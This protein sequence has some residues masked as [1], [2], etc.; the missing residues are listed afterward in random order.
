MQ[1]IDQ[2]SPQ[3]APDQGIWG[4]FG[5]DPRN[6]FTG[7]IRRQLPVFFGL[8]ALSAALGL[9]YLFTAVPTYI[10]TASMLIDTRKAQVFEQQTTRNDVVVDAG[11]VQSQIEVLKSENVSRAVIK[12]LKLTNDPEFAGSKD[13]GFVRS[14]LT[15]IFAI[16]GGAAEQSSPSL[17]MRKVLAAFEANR[18]VTRVGQSYVMEI[19]FQSTNPDKAARVANG[20]ADA[21]FDDQLQAKYEA[22]RR[23]SIW[24]QDRLE[25]LRAQTSAQQEAVANFRG[26]NNIVEAGG[27]LMNEQ[28]ISE[29]ASQL[30]LAQ[31]STAEAKARYDR[32]REVMT[33]DVPDASV[34][35]AL[36][37]DI[38][39]K[40]R[41]E[42]L[43]MAARE[44][45]WSGKYGA[46]HLSVVNLRT[47]MN[48]ILHSIKDEMRRIQESDKSDYEIAQAREKSIS[49]SLGSA[50]SQSRV[51]DQAQVQL[52]ELQSGAQT[53]RA[54]HDNF[55]QRYTEAVQQ[56]SFPITEA[57]LISPA[58]AP[59]S[60]SSPKTLLVLLL[61]AA[62][63]SIVSFGAAY[64]CETANRVFRSSEEVKEILQ[65][66][67]LGMLP[68]LKVAVRS[69]KPDEQPSPAAKPPSR[70]AL[71][72]QLFDYVLD[73]P[74]S[75]F[76]EGL[77]SLKMASDFNGASISKSVM[78]ITSTVPGEGKSTISANYAQLIAHAGK[79]ALLIDADLRNPCLSR[80][81][82]F[83]RPG[84]VDV[85]AGD[86]SVDDV[87]LIDP[88]SGLNFLP[89]GPKP[90]LPH[91]N[92]L[93]GSTSMME[94]IETLRSRF[95]YLIID[96]PPLIP[97]VDARATVN[98]IDSYIYVVEWGTTKVHAAKYALGNAPELYKRLLGVM[99]NK[100]NVSAARRY[101]RYGGHYLHDQY[102]APYGNSEAPVGV[103]NARLTRRI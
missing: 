11:M 92:E 94:L 64:A 90:L 27:K 34:A 59:L 52:L 66:N 16:F 55:L 74:F 4:P 61:T 8:L 100:V 62:A 46:N 82:A 39:I 30:I 77:R 97:V 60:K 58:D 29:V 78:G 79:R 23:A 84:L 5:P 89:A 91:T 1:Q 33:N 18:T 87:L 81:L 19:G 98:F 80:Q 43:D 53:S 17:V 37:S 85:L 86:K 13:P 38:I 49:D 57:R 50:V 67:C 95:D 7:V 25:E 2:H 6:L 22:T 65:V 75:Q 73:H 102:S 10:A 69:S 56:Q 103:S 48:E 71:R 21:Y 63:G 47:Q 99:M 24:L 40:L 31:A 96:L 26:K 15:P 101:E 3:D 44:A 93:L 14:I 54:I 42:Y 51:A 28:Q 36:K 45:Y 88:R 12:Q 72:S 83:D 32:I 20:I 41:G 68:R 9:T 35:D 70:R 76:T